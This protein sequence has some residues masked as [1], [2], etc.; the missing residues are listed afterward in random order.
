[1][2]DQPT[3]TIIR[4]GIFE[5]DLQTGELR[6]AG[7][8]VKLQAQP[9]RVLTLL[10]ERPG[11]I[12]TRA[13]IVRE[14]WGTG[15]FVDFDQAVAAVMRKLRRALGDSAAAPRYIETLRER[16]YRFLLPTHT[17]AAPY[18][19]LNVSAGVQHGAHP[20][21]RRPAFLSAS[22]AAAAALSLLLVV[23]IVRASTGFQQRAA[24]QRAPDH[25]GNVDA[26]IS[27]QKGRYL[28]NL[29]TAPAVEKSIDYFRRAANLNPDYAPAYAGLADAYALLNFYTGRQDRVS[30]GQ[31]KAAS[32]RA[33]RLDHSMA[34]AHAT[35][36]YIRFHYE[37]DWPGA[38]SAFRKAISLKP[39]YATARQWYA[40]YLFY[41]GRFQEALG[42]IT[43]AH[44]L[45]PQSLV[46]SVQLASPYLF[47]RDYPQAIR[48][49]REALSLNPEF[50]LAI[51]MLGTCYEQL[52]RFDEALAE[53]RKI[54]GTKLGL[55]GLGYAYG[56]SG[57]KED[58]RRLLR[59]LLNDAKRDDL[60]AYH[61]AR[62]Y[63]GLGETNQA[64]AWL[65]KAQD[66]RDERMVMLKVDPKL[67]SL[68]P[69]PLFRE[70][71]RSLDLA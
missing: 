67:D 15:T 21:F 63:A 60:S 70:L 41:M 10:L 38:E 3:R 35:R 62:V 55:T 28:W 68:R 51:Y 71:L 37:W 2:K 64:L 45:E 69:D 52:G 34:E 56:R 19:T 50:P 8:R 1:V 65:R 5:A 48:K 33:L 7:V 54:S 61:V 4:F 20:S 30:I 23:W 59:Q 16:G 18:A 57:R 29:R 47:S 31:A 39:S 13:E 26:Y 6:R 11:E 66:A 44:E 40:E 49:I 17:E 12:V 9:F 14:V 46:I 32:E 36:A 22:V 25:A 24:A 43:R 42:E 53:Y 58:A 27:Y